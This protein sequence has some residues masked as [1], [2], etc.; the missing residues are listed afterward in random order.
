M[1]AQPSL[2][3][4]F[5]RATI[6]IAI[7]TIL[8]VAVEW[9]LVYFTVKD[10][11]SLAVYFGGHGGLVLLMVC[12][13]LLQKMVGQDIRLSVL[14]TVM[15]AIA[16]PFG[17]LISLIMIT[18]FMGFSRADISFLQWLSDLFPEERVEKSIELYQR[19]SAGWDDF[20][21]KKRIMSFQDAIALGTIQQKREALAKISR[22][23]RRE[24]APALMGA[25]HDDNN[26]IRIQAATV[27]A[28]FEQEYMSEYMQLSRQH[29]A[30]PE[31][32]VILLKLAQ[33]ADAYAYSGILD[34]DREKDFS[35]LAVDSYAAYLKMKPDDKQAS[36]A[37]GRLYMNLGQPA[38]VREI[39]GGLMA[40]E[41]K[42]PLN[43]AMWLMESLYALGEYEEL[44]NLVVI[45][46]ADLTSAADN[47]ILIRNTLELWQKGMAREKLVI[48]TANDA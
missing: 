15:T 36:F 8:S 28:K 31:N 5:D 14:V 13:L 2:Q 23:F 7:V 30:D 33:Q 27:I 19:I 32:P 12:W 10:S 22:Y 18:F 41:N 6:G 38:R 44:R 1:E 40:G 48:K 11:L 42:P 35:E 24:F 45:Y 46:Q 34:P 9:A 37:L 25:L 16:G 47:P 3:T 17:S 43:Q 20:S 21:D 26:A 4:G 39:L 29:Q